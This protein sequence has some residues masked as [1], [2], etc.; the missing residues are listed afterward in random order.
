MES[1][2]LDPWNLQIRIHGIFRSGS[3][4]SSDPDPWNI[5]IQIHGIFRYGSGFTA[6]NRQRQINAT[7]PD[8]HGHVFLAPCKKRLVQCTL[9][10]TRTLDKSLFVTFQKH[11]AMYCITSDPVPLWSHCHHSLVVRR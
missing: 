6:P 2:D 10:H 7:R 1:S 4:E 11:M 8:K 3:M 5:Q 9:L